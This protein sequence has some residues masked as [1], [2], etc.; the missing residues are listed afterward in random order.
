MAGKS[1][2]V[3]KLTPGDTYDVGKKKP[4]MMRKMLDLY[5]KKK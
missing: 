5:R 4:S 2:K 3:D 1:T